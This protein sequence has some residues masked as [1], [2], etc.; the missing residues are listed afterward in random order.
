MALIFVSA[1]FALIF[2]F[3]KNI[4]IRSNSA[5]ILICIPIYGKFFI[6]ESLNIIEYGLW[7]FMKII[8]LL[9]PLLACA[10][11]L[12]KSNRNTNIQAINASEEKLKYAIFSSLRKNNVSY[13]VIGHEIRI[14]DSE[15]T[16][17]INYNKSN[18]TASIIFDNFQDEEFRKKI[19]KNICHATWES[20]E[21]GFHSSY[22][23]L[24]AAPIGLWIYFI[25]YNN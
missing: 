23:L 11:L 25:L 14:P 17:K 21:F 12:I 24:W 13:E 8:F 16:I 2:T 19:S 22:I 15:S 5:W 4:Y 7:D 18:L 3:K 20:I 6:R 9:S 1:L 10:Y